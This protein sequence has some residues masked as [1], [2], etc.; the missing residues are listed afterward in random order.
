MTKT[1][2]K[3]KFYKRWW[4]WL[5]VVIIIFSLF[6]SRGKDKNDNSSDKTTTAKKANSKN[7]ISREKYDKVQIGQ[8]KQEVK[9]ELGKPSYSSTT[10]VNGIESGLQT[11][12]N[13]S[14]SFKVSTVTVTLTNGKVSGKSYTKPIVG[15]VNPVNQKKLDTIQNGASYKDVIDQLGDP[16]T[17]NQLDLAG[18]N[19]IT[20]EYPTDKKGGAVSLTFNNDSLTTKTESHFN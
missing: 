19:S 3:K 7:E 1:K 16:A 6:G 14:S 15:K 11:W 10:T 4:F 2:N 12:N 18:Q 17:E 13:V 8:T 9:S 5:I 20:I